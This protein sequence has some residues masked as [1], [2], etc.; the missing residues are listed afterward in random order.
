[1]KIKEK[2]KIKKNKKWSYN[3]F[4]LI[5]ICIVMIFL[6]SSVGY[7]SGLMPEPDGDT[8]YNFMRF[9]L[10]NYQLDFYIP[11]RGIQLPHTMIGNATADAFNFALSGVTNIL[12]MLNVNLSFFTGFMIQEAFELDFI[13]RT[14]D[15]VARNMQA[16]WNGF[17]RGFL[18]YFVLFVGGYVAYHGMLKKEVSK[19]LQALLNFT[20]TFILA[21]AFFNATPTFLNMVNDFSRDMNTI[22]L[23]VGTEILLTDSPQQGS[24]QIRQ[25]LFELQ[26][27]QPY[28]I[29]Q[30]GST[31]VPESRWLP[32]LNYHGLEGGVRE[33]EY[34]MG[35]P[36]PVYR[37]T[38]RTDALE[39]EIE[40][41]GNSNMLP[42]GLFM[43]LIAII[44][45]GI[46]N[47]FVNLFSLI[48]AGLMIF[49]QLLFII[50][51]SFLGISIILSLLPAFSGIRKKAI[52]DLV[53]TFG[54]R[55]GVIMLATV[56]FLI[57][58]MIY[59]MTSTQ[60][61][62]F[63]MFLQVIAFV[64]IFF[65][66][67]K[68]LSKFSLET[69]ESQSLAKRIVTDP[70][71]KAFVMNR[72][73]RNRGRNRG[74]VSQNQRPTQ[75]EN[76]SNENATTSKTS[77]A[78]KVGN[79][80]GKV[81]SIPTKVQ[82]AVSRID[83]S[84]QNAPTKVKYGLHSARKNFKTGYKNTTNTAKSIA[85]SK[86]Q[87]S[88]EK[89]AKMRKE[90]RKPKESST[91]LKATNQRVNPNFKKGNQQFQ[92]LKKPNLKTSFKGNL[93]KFNQA[94]LNDKLIGQNDNQLNKPVQK[95]RTERKPRPEINQLKNSQ[96]AM[97]NGKPI[98]QVDN[99]PN[100]SIQKKKTERKSRPE[101]NQLK[102]NQ[103]TTQS[104][105]PIG[106]VDNKPNKSVQ[107]KNVER[108]PQIN[109][110]QNNQA[111]MLNGKPIGQVGNKSN[112][113]IQKK[114][115]KRKPEINQSQNN[116]TTT[117]NGKPIGQGKKNLPPRGGK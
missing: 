102:N 86:Q 70:L 75:T 65:T 19:A 67:G 108:R 54:L 74:N 117:L 40:E 68:I 92:L 3:A 21:T 7:A 37:S 60:P 83:D 18:P 109:Q 13:G 33:Y 77:M 30:F 34:I 48:L 112:E 61:L 66:T 115:S 17:S 72:M 76:G 29:L 31:D 46:F 45:I 97:L 107:K 24:N 12:W 88:K 22:A 11:S 93:S 44:I 79:K 23:N 59:S 57:S 14:I 35:D 28:K 114:N 87:E 89:L 113:P 36:L 110:S 98:E 58:A 4:V 47:F 71:K 25:M 80:I 16:I 52:L 2:K 8:N 104:G 85:S 84:I 81:A 42:Q 38:P 5:T 50:F 91:T 90:M 27:M 49:S 6:T 106:Q 43:R 32:F 94:T 64:G 55:I 99:K 78:S 95:K 10:R 100:K 9:P 62:A 41:L 63:V 105:K 39:Y 1:M 53:N 73:S 69:N 20:I 15:Y 101:I 111:A 56:T 26:V 103:T 116:Q 51:A 96:S 82:S